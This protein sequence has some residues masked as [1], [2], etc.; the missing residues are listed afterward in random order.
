[1][2]PVKSRRVG[3]RQPFHAGDQIGLRRFDHEM[4]M[5]RH[6]APCVN[7]PAGFFAGLAE[8]LNK[9]APIQVIQKDWFPAVSTIHDMVNCARIFYP[10]LS[11]RRII[12]SEEACPSTEYNNTRNR[13]LSENPNQQSNQ[14]PLLLNVKAIKLKYCELCFNPRRIKLWPA[15]PPDQFKTVLFAKSLS[16]KKITIFQTAMDKIKCR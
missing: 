11:D 5:V 9:T 13:P 10:Q 6:Q 15:S 4:K 8:S 2:P 12:L 1:M 14:L 3:A 7:L 16:K